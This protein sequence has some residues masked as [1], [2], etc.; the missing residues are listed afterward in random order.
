MYVEYY[1]TDCFDDNALSGYNM[2]SRFNLIL[3][4]MY[5]PSTKKIVNLVHE[6]DVIV[7]F[8]NDRRQYCVSGIKLT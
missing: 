3:I 2:V 8:N 7:N 1:H 4:V 6:H 5:I